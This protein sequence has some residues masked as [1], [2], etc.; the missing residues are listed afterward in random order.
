MVGKT[1]TH[2]KYK[3]TCSPSRWGS[4]GSW[5]ITAVETW[6]LVLR[7]LIG[8]HTATSI[9]NEISCVINH[10]LFGWTIWIY[11]LS[12]S[13]PDGELSNCHHN[14]PTQYVFLLFKVIPNWIGYSPS[15]FLLQLQFP[16]V[17]PILRLPIVTADQHFWKI[18]EFSSFNTIFLPNRDNLI[19][20][21]FSP[22]F[23]N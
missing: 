20:R 21:N 4:P 18:R 14:G 15:S 1:H 8:N 22:I 7:L 17:A 2:K 12:E 19:S 9:A 3:S 10:F 23:A 5:R 16:S 13:W 6:N 11:S